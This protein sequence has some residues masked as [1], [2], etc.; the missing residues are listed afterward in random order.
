MWYD[1]FLGVFGDVGEFCCGCV[2]WMVK[3]LLVY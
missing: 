2:G 1:D 3:Y